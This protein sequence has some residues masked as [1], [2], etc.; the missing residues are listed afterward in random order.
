MKRKKKMRVK[1]THMMTTMTRADLDLEA[2][3]STQL[4]MQGLDLV[5][6]KALLATIIHLG[7]LV[8]L[9]CHRLPTPGITITCPV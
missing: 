3:L 1:N 2:I 6:A 5:V 7:E 9:P 8:L 4:R